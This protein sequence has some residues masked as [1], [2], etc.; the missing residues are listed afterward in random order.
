MRTGTMK[1]DI[2][3]ESVLRHCI[4]LEEPHPIRYVDGIARL[5]T[6]VYAQTYRTVLTVAQS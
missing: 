6:D 1:P 2:T 3:E 5:C 4:T